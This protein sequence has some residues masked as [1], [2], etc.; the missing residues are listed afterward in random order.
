[1]SRRIRLHQNDGVAAQMHTI[2]DELDKQI[3]SA[4]SSY[5]NPSNSND[6][7]VSFIRNNRGPP[8]QS[9]G[10]STLPHPARRLLQHLGDNNGTPVVLT[11]EPWSLQRRDDAMARGSHASTKEHEVFLRVEMSGMVSTGF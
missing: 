10:L 6:T 3:F 5:Y 4:S 9:P 2:N 8:N 1:M 11:T 7:W